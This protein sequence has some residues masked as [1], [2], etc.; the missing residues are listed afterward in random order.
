MLLET[1]E[2]ISSNYNMKD[3]GEASC[4]LGIEIHRDKSKGVFELSQKAYI[5][6]VLRRYNMHKCSTSHAPIVKGDKFLDVSMSK[7]SKLIRCR[8][9]HTL[10][11]SEA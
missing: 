10:R 3:L 2:F 8:R 4:V 5:Y 1:K 7:E 9:F 11:L 6:K